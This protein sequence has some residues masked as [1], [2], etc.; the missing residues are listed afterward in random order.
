M[1]R[2]RPGMKGS[3]INLSGLSNRNDNYYS[4]YKGKNNENLQNSKDFILDMEI[5]NELILRYNIKESITIDASNE[6]KKFLNNELKE[7]LKNIIQQL[8]EYNRRRTYSNN[9]FFTKHNRIISYGINVLRDPNPLINAKKNKFY[10]TK[11]LNL[12]CTINVDKRL[13]LL[14]R[15]NALKNNKKYESDNEDEKKD[16]KN[17]EGDD[18]DG[19]V[20]KND[21]ES[22]SSECDFFQKKERKNSDEINDN[23]KGY[24]GIMNVYQSHELTTNKNIPFKKHRMGHVELKDLIY[25]LEENQTVPLNKIVLFKAYTEMTISGK[26]NK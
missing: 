18:D 11:N 20:K 2:G 9:I 14:N 21:N 23:K 17:D 6:A 15:Y 10:P 19:D 25:Y 12:M 13:N 8:I 3:L 24:Q 22:D 5:L 26:D 1:K 16:D 7:Y 4:Y